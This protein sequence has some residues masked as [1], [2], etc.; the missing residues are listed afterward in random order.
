M[1]CECIKDPNKCL[2][3]IQQ[4]KKKQKIDKQ[5]TLLR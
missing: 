5:H 3:K 1:A 4:E 2:L